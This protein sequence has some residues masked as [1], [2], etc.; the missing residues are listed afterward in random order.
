M[1]A[2]AP[3]SDLAERDWLT[4]AECARIIGG[5]VRTWRRLAK[6]GLVRA[7]RVRG[8][9]AVNSA[10]RVQINQVS[11]RDYYNEIG[12]DES[13]RAYA[14]FMRQ[15]GYVKQGALWRKSGQHTGENIG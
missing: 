9:A 3:A 2:I 8:I 5:T 14:E 1:P 12:I 4:P 7:R 11:A 6:Q 10:G 15:R 13:E